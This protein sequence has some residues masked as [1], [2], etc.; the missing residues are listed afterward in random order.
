MRA[1]SCVLREDH[2]RRKSSGQARSGVC[3]AGTG[4]RHH[5]QEDMAG[6]PDDE[7]WAAV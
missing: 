4:Y 3:R 5:S 2:A 7:V 6:K 1:L